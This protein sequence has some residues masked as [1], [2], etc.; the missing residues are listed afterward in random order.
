MAEVKP[1]NIPLIVFT[2]VVVISGGIWTEMT[3]PEYFSGGIT[4]ITILIMILGSPVM[5]LWTRALWNT[6]IPRITGWREITFWEAAG[7]SAF[8]LFFAG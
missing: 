8:V 2:L 6:V 4:L 1:L 3:E 5:I 7:V